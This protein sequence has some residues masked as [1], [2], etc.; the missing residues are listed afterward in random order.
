MKFIH[1]ICRNERGAETFDA[2]KG[3]LQR[4]GRAARELCGSERSTLMPPLRW[5]L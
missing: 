5:D 3:S 1:D 4:P 2:A